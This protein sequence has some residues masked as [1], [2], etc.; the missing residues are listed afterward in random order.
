VGPQI[1]YIFPM[2]E[3]LQGYLNLKG[4]KEFAAQNRPEG[5]NTWLIF[6]IRLR[7]SSLRL[8]SRSP[9]SID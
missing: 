8:R 9:A 2:G 7:R 5:W 4:H 3:G 1:G 6:A